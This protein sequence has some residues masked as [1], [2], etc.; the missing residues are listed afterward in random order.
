MTPEEFA[1]HLK[2]RAEELRRAYADR[3]PRMMRAEAVEH[4]REGFRR[5]GFIDKSLD[6]WDVT[7]RQTV[8]FNGAPGKYTPLNSRTG[9]LMHSIDGRLEPGGVTIFSDEPHAAIHNE[10]GRIP[11]T[12]RM[13]RFFWAMHYESK[14]KYGAKNPEA[15]FWARMALK[16]GDTI[17]IPQRRF[18]GR[19]ASLMKKLTNMLQ[20]DLKRIL[21]GK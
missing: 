18:L 16:R 9:S 19:S 10:G 15:Q 3:W 17:R 20:R 5:G 2:A 11:V 8:P 12:K 21:N 1:K 6:K 13:R 7:R 14:Q 4:F